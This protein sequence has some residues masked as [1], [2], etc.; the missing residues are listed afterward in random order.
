MAAILSL[1]M[2]NVSIGGRT[3]LA[4]VFTTMSAT[5]GFGAFGTAPVTVQPSVTGAK[6]GNEALASLLTA[7]AAFGLITDNT[8]A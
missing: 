3:P 5:T 6:G 4:A 8:T 2:D 1:L 7:L